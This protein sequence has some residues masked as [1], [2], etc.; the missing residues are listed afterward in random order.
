M[1]AGDDGGT[2][3]ALTPVVEEVSVGRLI[4][5][6]SAVAA[7]T[8]GAGPVLAQDAAQVEK[9]KAVYDAQRCSL[10]HAVAGRGNAKG[11]LDKV[12][13]RLSAADIRKWIVSPKE[14]QSETN[15]KPDM[16]AYPS[17]PAADLD[18]L[19]AYMQSLKG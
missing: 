13:A 1:G 10:C 18:A 2:R 9:G 12:G 17:L 15:R 7:L 14:M 4:Q 19:V 16:R 8:F 6:M 11:P 5:V 3:R